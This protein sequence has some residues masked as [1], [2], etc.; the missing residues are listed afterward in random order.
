MIEIIN[1]R[2][3][4]IDDKANMVEIDDEG[5]I[6]L[7]KNMKKILGDITFDENLIKPIE[8]IYHYIVE[9][10][11][12]LPEYAYDASFKEQPKEKLLIAFNKFFFDK[13]H[14]NTRRNTK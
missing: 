8:P 7:H 13:I 6:E 11:Y 12:T 5:L 4:L 2:I 3:I 10:I 9:K 1:N 14:E